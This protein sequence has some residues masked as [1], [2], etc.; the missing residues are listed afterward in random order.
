MN[1]KLV[2]LRLLRPLVMNYPNQEF[3]LDKCAKAT[4]KR[5]GLAETSKIDLDADTCIRGLE[6]DGTYRFPGVNKDDG[7]QHVPP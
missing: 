4:F 6:P 2:Y 3:A 1:A 7:I 5:S